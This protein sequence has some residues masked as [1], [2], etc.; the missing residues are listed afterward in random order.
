ME[1]GEA[2]PHGKRETAV[3]D[4]RG[5]CPVPS[6]G[7]HRLLRTLRHADASFD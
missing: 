1:G 5:S 2:K 6:A 7:A 3:G 4:E